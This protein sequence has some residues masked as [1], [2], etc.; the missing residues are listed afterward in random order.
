MQSRTETE[1]RWVFDSRRAALLLGAQPKGAC[2]PADCRGHREVETRWSKILPSS[3]LMNFV[4]QLLKLKP[5]NHFCA[6]MGIEI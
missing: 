2:T 6:S 1:A 5:K 4:P 3:P